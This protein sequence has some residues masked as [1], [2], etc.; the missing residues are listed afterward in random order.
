MSRTLMMILAG[1]LVFA[2]VVVSAE[3][4]TDATHPAT[5]ATVDVCSGHR[6]AGNRKRGFAPGGALPPRTGR[7]V[8]RLSDRVAVLEEEFD[9][10]TAGAISKPES[11]NSIELDR[12]LRGLHREAEA[13]A[14]NIAAIVRRLEHDDNLL[15]ASARNWQQRASFLESQSVPAAVLERSRSIKTKLQHASAR[16]RE[17]RD[18]ALLGLDRALAL[19]ARLEE[20]RALITARQDRLDS[21][22]KVLEQSPIWRLGAAS[23]QF[24]LVGGEFGST[25]KMQRDYLV[26][27]GA[28]LV[29][30]FLFIL[31]LTAWLFTRRAGVAADPIQRAYGRPIA[32][33]LLIALMSVWWLAPDPPTLFYEALLLLV[34]IPAAMVARSALAAPIP[35]TL[36]GVALATM[37]IPLRGVIEASAIANRSC[38]C[39][40]CWLPYR[41]PSTCATGVC[42]RHSGGRARVSVRAAALL[43]LA[44]AAVTAFHVIFG[45]TGPAGSLRAG[46]GSILGFGLVFGA[47]AAG[48]SMARCLRSLPRR[49]GGSG[50]RATPIRHYCGQLRLVLTRT[51]RRRRGDRHAGSLRSHSDNASWRASH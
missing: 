15:E 10:L 20:A 37:L 7:S 16:V 4:T 40:K 22:R 17:F 44:A 51:C 2:P 46:M 31:A 6:Q 26:Q 1:T 33:S 45:F 5:G 41:S 9:T 48:R 27:D 32:A 28:G 19:Q 25:W 47:S 24:K 38:C 12:H 43:V 35:L 18:N 49:S 36:Y 3:T 39:C 50:A 23:D 42:S 21:Q 30:L 11:I 29:G 14:D 13:I 34:P 8:A